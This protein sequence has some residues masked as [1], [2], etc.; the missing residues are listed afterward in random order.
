MTPTHTRS[1]ASPSRRV[2]RLASITALVAFLGTGVGCSTLNLL[3]AA[4]RVSIQNHSDARVTVQH[5]RGRLDYREPTGIA[6]WRMPVERTVPAGHC[7]QSAIGDARVTTGYTDYVVR[8]RMDYIDPVT[9]DPH[10]EWMELKHPAPYRVVIDQDEQGIFIRSATDSPLAAVPESDRI[11][12]HLDDLP[13]W[14]AQGA[15]M[16]LAAQ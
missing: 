9:F 16:P 1:L 10:T 4:P 6:D 13:V 14:D 11:P 3:P 12:G 15:H 8:L 7:V 5:W 2:F